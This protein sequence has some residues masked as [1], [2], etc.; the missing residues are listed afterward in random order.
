MSKKKHPI[1]IGA[2]I[3]FIAAM[4]A[5][6]AVSEQ[7]ETNTTAE[8]ATAAPQTAL[9]SITPT[10]APT[11]TPTATPTLS[12]TPTPIPTLVPT[13]NA[14]SDDAEH[15]VWIPTNG[16]TK[17][18]S[19]SSCSKMKNPQKVTVKQAESGGYTPCQRCY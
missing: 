19:N 15:M 17:Y 12:P 2:I 13:A 18:H 14:N 9:P 3:C 5:I 11:A 4:I 6:G 1:L 8:E 10:T 7:E 16:G